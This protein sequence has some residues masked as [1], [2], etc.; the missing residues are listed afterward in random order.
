LL[1]HSSLVSSFCKLSQLNFAKLAN[2]ILSVSSCRS[3]FTVK[4]SLDQGRL[5]IQ[6]R[7]LRI[8][9]I[10]CVLAISIFSALKIWA[11]K[12]DQPWTV[13]FE[14][15]R[16]S[17]DNAK[18][19][20]PRAT[21]EDRRQRT[22]TK[23]QRDAMKAVL[24]QADEGAKQIHL[25]IVLVSPYQEPARYASEIV[26]VFREAGWNVSEPRLGTNLQ[27]KFYGKYM[28]GV[29]VIESRDGMSARARM[30]AEALTAAGVPVVFDNGMTLEAD[31]LLLIGSK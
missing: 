24:E 28:V 8:V 21:I 7:T 4:I 31:C 11:E 18:T 12:G 29:T 2:S 14:R 20:R 3:V 16:A 10:S 27:F 9:A 25:S 23:D 26:G 15:R 17:T 19:D 5:A 22:L 30:I 6:K 13:L 1:G